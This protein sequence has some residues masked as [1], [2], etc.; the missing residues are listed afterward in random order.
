[1]TVFIK[2]KTGKQYQIL[3]KVNNYARFEKFYKLVNSKI[4]VILQDEF[5]ILNE[6]SLNFQINFTLLYKKINS[7]KIIITLTYTCFLNNFV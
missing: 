6:P 5:Y 4:N 7:I 3:Q 2:S 1:M